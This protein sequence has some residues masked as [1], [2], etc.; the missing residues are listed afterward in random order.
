MLSDMDGEF[1]RIFYETA[2]A[3]FYE[4]GSTVGSALARE[5]M[6]ASQGRDQRVQ[7]AI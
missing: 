2:K 4:S 7:T 6:L 3:R 5:V 1:R